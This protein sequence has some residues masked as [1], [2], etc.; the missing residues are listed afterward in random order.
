MYI[1]TSLISENRD[2]DLRLIGNEVWL[3]GVKIF[4]VSE[5]IT[6]GRLFLDWFKDM[7]KV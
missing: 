7:F 2:G 4:E 6:E 5:S 3:N 1:S